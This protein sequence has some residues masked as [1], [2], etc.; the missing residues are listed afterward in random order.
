LFVRLNRVWHTKSPRKSRE[1]H[2]FT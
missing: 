1:T 2:A